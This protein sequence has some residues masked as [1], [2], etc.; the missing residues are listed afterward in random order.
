M[1]ERDE[2]SK[3]SRNF[4]I[5]SPGAGCMDCN[6]AS[7]SAAALCRLNL[8][9]MRQIRLILTQISYSDFQQA[10]ERR[11]DHVVV[12]KFLENVAAPMWKSPLERGSS[13]T[14]PRFVFT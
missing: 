13:S 5:S 8:F 4:C 10:I 12:Q 9:T 2:L 6:S 1:D 3:V 7:T 11:G 14:G